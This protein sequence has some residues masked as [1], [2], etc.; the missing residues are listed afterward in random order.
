[1]LKND[2][3]TLY[4]NSSYSILLNMEKCVGCTQCVRACSTISGQNILEC[5]TRHKSHTASGQLLADTPCISCGQ[6]S[7]VCPMA[8][9][10]EHFNKDEVTNVLNDKK[11][12][13]VVCQFA[14][15][16]RINMAEALGVDVGTISTGKIVTAL[17]LLN[18]IIFL[19]LLLEQI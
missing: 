19:I 18:L 9:I 16:V 11:G 17:K 14:P 13:I 5:E 15:A 12:K 1:M 10:T 3:Q 7:L 2:N 4:D 8:A 6:C